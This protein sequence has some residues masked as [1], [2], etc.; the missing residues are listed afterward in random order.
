[1]RNLII[2]LLVFLTGCASI[3]NGSR[4]VVT[5]KTLDESMSDVIKCSLKNEEGEWETKPF[6]DTI[7]SRDGNFMFVSCENNE[8]TVESIIKPEFNSNL[9]FINM[10]FDLCIFSC[11]V[12]G[13]NN[14]FYEYPRIIPIKLGQE[15][16]TVPVVLSKNNSMEIKELNGSIIFSMIPKNSRFKVAGIAVGDKLIGINGVSVNEYNFHLIQETL[17]EFDVAISIEGKGVTRIRGYE[18]VKKF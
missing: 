12:D 1:M 2:I 4:Q 6:E 15:P 3:S 7:I 18:V 5:I 13:I 10:F 8:N 11:I 9:L 14:A 16:I 17:N